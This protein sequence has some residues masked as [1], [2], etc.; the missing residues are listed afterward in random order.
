LTEPKDVNVDKYIENLKL[1][2]HEKR[3]DAYWKLKDIRDPTNHEDVSHDLDSVIHDVI[4]MKEYQTTIKNL[5][6]LREALAQ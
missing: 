2:Y 5:N 3:N 1:N 6:I 4:A